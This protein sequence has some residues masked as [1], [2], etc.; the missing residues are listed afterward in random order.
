MAIGDISDIIKDL[1]FDAVDSGPSRIIHV[2]GDVYL[3]GYARRS[4]GSEGCYLRTV[5]IDAAGNIGAEK[6]FLYIDAGTYQ[7]CGGLV[8]VYGDV[9]AVTFITDT[10]NVVKTF[11]VDS[12]GNIG[13]AEIDN[14]DLSLKPSTA[15]FLPHIVHVT[16][17][18]FAVAYTDNADD[19]FVA[20]IRINNNG[21]IDEPVLASR[22][23]EPVKGRNVFLLHCGDSLFALITSSTASNRGS[24]HTM[25]IDGTGAISWKKEH[26][27]EP[28]TDGYSGGV[29]LPIAGNNYVI[30]YQG[31]G[32]DGWMD[33]L[34][35]SADGLTIT[36]IDSW[37]YDPTYG[38]S[39][40]AIEISG[41]EA[42]DG[43]VYLVLNGASGATRPQLQTIEVLNDGTI[44]ESTI[45]TQELDAGYAFTGGLVHIGSVYAAVYYSAAPTKGA[46]KTFTVIRFLVP[47][48]TTDAATPVGHTSATLIGTLVTSGGE[49]CACRFE[50]GETDNYGTETATQSKGGGE[51]FSQE[52]R[53]LRPGGITYHFRAIATNSAGTSRGADRTFHTE[54]LSAEAHQALGKGYALG[55]AGL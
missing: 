15:S 4:G 10:H 34:S 43:K 30:F 42:G 6:D 33:T 19:A 29:I 41:N 47:T 9:Y 45:D 46:V 20:T 54:A 26:I 11:T 53:G 5:P 3:I 16:G 49:D 48:V 14:I 51:T 35:I 7:G 24:I 37:E 39:P 13:A 38:H 36:N 55:R 50:Y 22:E 17:N 2:S 28:T 18:V 27:F 23:F 8:H 21:S 12:A 44:T 32:S 1:T 40:V 25:T 31:A 52:V